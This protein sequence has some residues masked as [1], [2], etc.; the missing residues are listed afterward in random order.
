MNGSALARALIEA[1]RVIEANKDKLCA[2]DSEI[3]DGD[4]GVSMTIG[5]RTARSALEALVDPRPADAFRAVGAAFADEVGASCGVL[6]E[7]GFEAAAH[8]AADRTNL[9]A[10]DWAGIFEALVDEMRR[11]GGAGEGDKTMMDA[12]I[13]AARA[14]RQAATENRNERHGLAAA[15]QAAESGAQA[16]A[17]LVARFGRASRLGERARG[18]L[19]AGAASAALIIRALSDAT[20]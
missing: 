17:D 20:N 16:T 11:T 8:A 9:A 1:T 3:G 13:P 12:W 7:V 18:H 14:L 4:H 5:M 19:D 15:A 10:A 6:Y 2:L